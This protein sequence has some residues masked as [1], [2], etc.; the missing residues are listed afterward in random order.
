[1]TSLLLAAE[2]TKENFASF[3]VPLWAW[4]AFVALVAALLIADLLLVHRSAHVISFK[5]AAIESAVWIAIGL[6][7]TF[8]VLGWHGGQAAGRQRV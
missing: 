5:E 6:S 2:E 3:D 1:M 8:L 7:F 4:G